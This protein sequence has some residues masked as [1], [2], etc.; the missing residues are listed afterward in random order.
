MPDSLTLALQITLIGMSLVF[1]SI[2]LL[3]IVMSI[4]VRLTAD[5]AAASVEPR[6]KRTSDA[7]WELKQRAAAAAV[8]IALAHDVESSSGAFPLPPTAFVSAWQAVMRGQQLKQRGPV[9][10]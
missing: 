2:V 5:R 7:E 1:G 3:W 4:L 10:K 6:A 9:R 8:A